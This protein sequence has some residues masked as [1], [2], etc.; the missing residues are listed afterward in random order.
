MLQDIL[1][2]KFEYKRLETSGAN[3]VA[4]MVGHGKLTTRIRQTK[5]V[6]FKRSSRC[7]RDSRHR[8]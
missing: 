4:I 7:Q 8:R 1:E 5:W 6:V 2:R 3:N